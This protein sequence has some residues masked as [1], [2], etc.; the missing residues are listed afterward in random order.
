MGPLEPEMF[1]SY[2]SWAIVMPWEKMSL[3]EKLSN[4][5]K[6]FKK[7]RSLFGFDL[8]E[9]FSLIPFIRLKLLVRKLNKLESF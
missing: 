6:S 5:P 9:D 1:S 8:N 2:P 4:Y 3:K 7:N